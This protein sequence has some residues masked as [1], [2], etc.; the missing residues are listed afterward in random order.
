M[1]SNPPYWPSPFL[2]PSSSISRS[3]SKTYNLRMEFWDI[4]SQNGINKNLHWLKGEKEEIKLRQPQLTFNRRHVW[5]L[6]CWSQESIAFK[7]INDQHC[8]KSLTLP[9]KKLETSQIYDSISQ[10]LRTETSRKIHEA[11]FHRM[12]EI[13]GSPPEQIVWLMAQKALILRDRRKKRSDRRTMANAVHF[14]F[15]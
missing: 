10:T 14:L 6:R 11:N 4:S 7:D 9:T 13:N 2:I 8:Q 1:L 3:G 5:T 15:R 12:K